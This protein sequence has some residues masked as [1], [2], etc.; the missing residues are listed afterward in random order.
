MFLLL[1]ALLGACATETADCVTRAEFDAAV[2]Q[3]LTSAL[4]AQR[5]D[6]EDD[7]TLAVPT[8]HAT[9]QD[10][11]DWLDGRWIHADATVTIQI[12]AGTYASDTIR[13]AHP[14][15]DRVAI[16]GD[17]ADASQVVL[18]FSGV[19]GVE[20]GQGATLG[21]LDGVTLVGD[22][23][24]PEVHGVY[25][26][27]GATLS[28]GP[29][30]VVSDFGGKGFYAYQGGVIVAQHT[31]SVGNA[32]GYVAM[33]GSYIDAF[34]ALAVGNGSRGFAA[35]Y[36]SQLNAGQSI[37]DDNGG[38][39]YFAFASAIDAS[40]TTATSNGGEGLT[41]SYG[42]V[43]AADSIVVAANA[44]AARAEG[45]SFLGLTNATFSDNGAGVVSTN[46]SFVDAS[47]A[48]LTGAGGALQ[49]SHGSAADTTDATI[50]TTEPAI[51]STDPDGS[52]IY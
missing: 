27:N 39:G 21:A 1:S 12:A 50:D 24:T 31:V 16:L 4:A 11:L 34:G 29:Q 38:V 14:N 51:V 33:Y 26:Y 36:N 20:L 6:I 43:I 35:I 5:T 45:S 32:D 2:D 41:A 40:G 13:I 47:R 17:T 30:V 10:A 8:E 18:T 28:C 49:A 9:V 15:G 48:S 3:A 22:R 7:L 42:G 19:S 46:G 25:V 44:G 52:H 23:V 37:A